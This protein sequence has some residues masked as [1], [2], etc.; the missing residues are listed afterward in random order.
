MMAKIHAFSS[1]YPLA[2]N[3]P[4]LRHDAQALQSNVNRLRT[5]L[6]LSL[7]SH[8]D[9]EILL[10]AEQ[11]VAQDL[12][13]LGTHPSVWGPIHGDIHYDNVLIYDQEIRP[14]DFSGLRLGHYVY[15][16]GVTL[17]HIFYQGS[18]MRQAFLAGYQQIYPL[19]M[20]YEQFVEACVVY[21][22][23]D[24]IA[25]NSSIPE[26]Q[27]APLFQRNLQDLINHYCIWIAQ[28]KHFLLSE[29]SI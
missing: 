18:Q 4:A 15:D 25:W 21:A 22:A 27:T 20:K 23:I 19:P 28:G 1:T 14:I 8:Q 24:N 16:I 29:E 26:Q 6:P 5:L 2:D 13:E 3:V 12:A 7:L 9:F 11:R 10:A 17:Y